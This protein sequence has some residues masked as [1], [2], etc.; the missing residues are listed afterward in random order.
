MSPHP[1]SRKR[2]RID[3][4]FL[5]MNRTTGRHEWAVIRDTCPLN[6]RQRTP[7]R[8]GTEPSFC[9]TNGA[10]WAPGLV[11]REALRLRPAPAARSLPVADGLRNEGRGLEASGG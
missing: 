1:T 8:R 4:S 6:F 9:G 2:C 3:P 10:F 5:K 11:G 7:V